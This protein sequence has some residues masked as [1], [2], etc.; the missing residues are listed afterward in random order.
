MLTISFQAK[1]DINW[2]RPYKQDKT[3]GHLPYLGRSGIDSFSMSHE[4]IP[5]VIGS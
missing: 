2:S 3:K 5:E 1:E 4:F